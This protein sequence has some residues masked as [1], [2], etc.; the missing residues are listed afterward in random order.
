MN[1]EAQIKNWQNKFNK[2]QSYSCQTCHKPV[3]LN[4][5]GA[6]YGPCPHCN[7][8]LRVTSMFVEDSL[9]LSDGGTVGIGKKKIYLKH[10]IVFAVWWVISI[11]VAAVVTGL[12]GIILS[13]LFNVLLTIIGFRAFTFV[14]RERDF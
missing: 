1:I 7:T 13:I 11:I 9:N 2:G 8:P 3:Y 14:I 12:P 4:R 5:Q 10:L 6:Y